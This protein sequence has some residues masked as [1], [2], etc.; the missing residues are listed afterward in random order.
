MPFL[1]LSQDDTPVRE[2]GPPKTLTSERSFPPTS[3]P[4][5]LRARCRELV[6]ALLPR[7]L[8]VRSGAV[9]P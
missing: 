8:E 9:Q 6:A 7:L 4:G 5:A 3:D 2:R 1:P